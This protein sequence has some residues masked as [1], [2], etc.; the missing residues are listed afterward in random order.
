MVVRVSSVAKTRDAAQHEWHAIS[1]K[2]LLGIYCIVP[3]CILAQLLDSL[4]F[5]GYLRDALPAN[6]QQFFLFQIL[7]GTPHILAS[8][9]ILFGNPDYFSAYRNRLLAFTAFVAV[10]YLFGRLFLSY[11]TLFFLVATVTVTHV[12]RQQHGVARGLCR[13]PP[14]VAGALLW[15][16]VAAGVLIYNGMFLRKSFSEE[17]LR[18][19][20][21]GAGVISALLLV[22]AAKAYSLVGNSAGRRYLWANAALVPASWYLFDQQYYFLA[23]LGPR[24][25]HDITAFVFYMA[26]DHNRHQA[27]PGNWLYKAWSG[28]GL[29]VFWAPPVLAIGLT[30]FLQQHGDALFNAL[31]DGVFGMTIP[32]AVSFGLIGYLGLVHYFT[33]ATCW[34]QGSPQRKYILFKP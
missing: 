10:F 30:V 17:E 32:G 21:G 29:P 9:L 5:G 19:I 15:L 23:I 24:L 34:K 7:F 16:S 2:T 31:W 12:L 25:V 27:R 4:F 8:S 18:L 14:R 33:E 3:F 26:H 1:F 13:L 20:G 6:P 22:I 11:N 28:L